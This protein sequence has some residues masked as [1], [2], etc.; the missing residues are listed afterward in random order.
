MKF[1]I[2]FQK[3]MVPMVTLAF[4]FVFVSCVL[5]GDKASS[6]AVLVQKGES[7]LKLGNN[8]LAFQSFQKAAQLGDAAGECRLGN[9]YW[10]AKG[11]TQ[12]LNE[13]FLWY[14]KSA[15]QGYPRGVKRFGS[16]LPVWCGGQHKLNGSCEIVPKSFGS[17]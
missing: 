1:L 2:R 13:T 10:A 5:A 3:Y 12:D 16:L 8:D 6:A 17:P 11:V 9:C 4:G 14:K 7:A 15:D